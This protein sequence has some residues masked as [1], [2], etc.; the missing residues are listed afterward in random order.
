MV[1]AQLRIYS[2]KYY[3]CIVHAQLCMSVGDLSYM[4]DYKPLML[5]VMSIL[6]SKSNKTYRNMDKLFDRSEKFIWKENLKSSFTNKLNKQSSKA[7]DNN[8]FKD[9]GDE[10]GENIIEKVERLFLS[11]AENVLPTTA[12]L[13]KQNQKHTGKKLK[14]DLIMSTEKLGKN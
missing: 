3:H 5:K 1:V 10:N 2:S 7:F 6:H 13:P 12:K 11:T 14:C 9:K 8:S 4:S